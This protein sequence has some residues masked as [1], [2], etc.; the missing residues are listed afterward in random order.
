[1]DDSSGGPE[2]PRRLTVPNLLSGLRLATV[3]IFV[4]LFISGHTNAAVIL[5]GCAA[6]TD[7]FDGWIARRLGQVSDLGKLLDP[8]ADRV[9]ILALTVMLV[10]KGTLVWWVAAAIIVRDLLVLGVYPLLERRGLERI[11]VNLVGKMATALLLFGL[12]WL[13]VSA[14]TVSWHRGAH[15]IGFGL[16]LVGVCLY[17]VATFMYGRDVL[18]RLRSSQSDHAL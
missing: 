15:S 5:Y 7:F 16:V 11:P 17:W 14:T 3:P 9:F 1:M 10:I 12:T 13:A 4:G 18:E 6:W 8:L 2:T